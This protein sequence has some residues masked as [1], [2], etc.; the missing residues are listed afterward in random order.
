MYLIWTTALRTAGSVHGDGKVANRITRLTFFL[1][2]RRFGCDKSSYGLKLVMLTCSILGFR[3]FLAY[4]VMSLCNHALSVMC[5]CH[6]HCR[7]HHHRCQHWHLCT[8]LPVTGLIIETS[9]LTNLCSYAP[10][11]CT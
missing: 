4:L 5:R 9:Y 11:I 8:A 2:L 10:S 6:C 7:H 3:S 1:G